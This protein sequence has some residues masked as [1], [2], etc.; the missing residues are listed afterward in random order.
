M[1]RIPVTLSQRGRGKEAAAMTHP[2]IHAR[3]HPDKIAYHKFRHARTCA[4]HP[5]LEKFKERK[6]VDGRDI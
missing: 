5:R 6:N 2:Y 4:G 3:S 1:L